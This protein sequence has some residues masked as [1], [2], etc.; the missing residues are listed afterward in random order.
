MNFNEM[1]KSNEN[2]IRSN[3]LNNYCT[4]F[5]NSSMPLNCTKQN[6]I[7]LLNN[8]NNNN[9]NNNINVKVEPKAGEE[10]EI[11]VENMLNELKTKMQSLSDNLLNK[12]D[13]MEKYLDELENIMMNYTTQNNLQ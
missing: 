13:N 8:D 3:K 10:L 6:N 12:V 1:L 5:N 9:N 11:Y 7:S 2:N 4:S